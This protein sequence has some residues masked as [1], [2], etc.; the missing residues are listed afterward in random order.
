MVRDTKLGRSWLLGVLITA[1][2][3]VSSFAQNTSGL[4]D[5]SNPN[6]T[7]LAGLSVRGFG[8]D[9]Y[10]NWLFDNGLLGDAIWTRENWGVLFIPNQGDVG[11][12]QDTGCGGSSPSVGNP[13]IL[14]TGAKVEQE[15]DF[16]SLG[17]MA[18]SLRRTYISNTNYV[19]IFG[20]KWLGNFDQRLTFLYQEGGWYCATYPGSRPCDAPATPTIVM[21]VRPDG[22][23]IKFS[24]NS[25][26][27]PFPEDKPG[28]V[29]HL[30][31]GSADGTWYQGYWTL[32]TENNTVEVYRWGI[33]QSVKDSHGV[34]YVLAYGGINGTQLQSV[35]HSS[36]RQLHFTW[37]GEYLVEVKDPAG[38]QYHYSYD[39]IGG[40]P[41]LLSVVLPG[42]PSSTVSYVYGNGDNA[43]RLIGK[44]YGGVRYSYFDY[45][46]SGRGILSE[47]AGGVERY[48]F[49]YTADGSGAVVKVVEV[50]PLGKK[51][52]YHF[53]NGKLTS[54]YGIQSANCAASA[55]SRTYDVRGY[56]NEVIDFAGSKTDFDY[57]DHGHLIKRVDAAGTPIAKTTTYVWDEARNMIASATVQGVSRTDYTYTEDSRIEKMMVTDL[58]S[59]KVRTTTYSY[60]KHA[61]GLLATASVDGPLPNDTTTFSYS[62][63]GDLFEVKNALGQITR[64]SN[65]NALGQPGR[66][67][68]PAGAMFDVE[69][70]ARGR[71]VEERSYPNGSAVVTRFVYGASGL[72]DAKTTS[73]GNTAYYHYDSARRLI[74]ADLTEPGGGHS[75]KRYTYDAMS[76]PIKIEMGRDN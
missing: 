16:E 23:S 65:F 67:A 3:P 42:N 55:R 44:S 1:G 64:Y 11:S 46:A 30:V 66:I 75:V 73:D 58:S 2:V 18:L 13:I 54:T 20:L 76:N 7:T 15:T 6:T 72:L 36:G 26:R 60:T 45:D 33:L 68:S 32:H 69:Y 24:T 39:S 51:T 48:L 74:Q 21:A 62:A 8:V 14:A 59:G 41:R 5:R 50:N 31:P 12:N 40:K 71:V 19:G 63:Q 25:M 47:H 52:E 53:Q 57:D 35:T 28:P 70:D 43:S 17:D 10:H 27:G 9:A 56:E 22:R 49:S 37:S 4:E 38:N 29:A 61:S 34:G